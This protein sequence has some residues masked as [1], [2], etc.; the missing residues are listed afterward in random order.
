MFL[1]KFVSDVVAPADIPKLLAEQAE[2]LRKAEE[3]R[4]HLEKLK[5]TQ[6]HKAVKPIVGKMY[7][8]SNTLKNPIFDTTNFPLMK[9][10]KHFFTQCD[11]VGAVFSKIDYYLQHPVLLVNAISGASYWICLTI[12]VGGL[13]Y[14]LIGNKDGL[15]WMK[16]SVL[17]YILIETVNK[18]ASFL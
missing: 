17:G 10:F 2:N 1:S 8:A 12:A 18:G 16:G 3:I 4:K 15:K 6:L 11:K 9:E 5:E 7:D 13:L 14:Y